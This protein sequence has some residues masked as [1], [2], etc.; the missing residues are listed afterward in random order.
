MM[1]KAEKASILNDA[2]GINLKPSFSSSVLGPQRK[3]KCQR[4]RRIH[5]MEKRNL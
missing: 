1:N 4:E 5:F 3:V 2:M